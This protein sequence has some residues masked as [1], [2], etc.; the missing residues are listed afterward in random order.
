[1]RYLFS[2]K[3]YLFGKTN[4]AT[5]EVKM[6][7]IV[8]QYNKFPIPKE[9]MDKL[10]EIA[11]DYSKV[12]NHVYQRYGGIG[13][14]S[15][16]YPGYTVQ[17][18]MT[19]SG[20]RERLG[21]PSVYF[22]LAIFDALGDIKTQWSKTRNSILEAIRKNETFSD[23]DRHYIRAVLKSEKAWDSVLIGKALPN[24]RELPDSS[25]K[26]NQYLRRQ[27]RKY[28][29]KM[30]TDKVEGFSIGERAYRYADDGIY[31]ST[32]EKRQRVYVPLTDNNRYKRQLKIMLHPEDN[33]L[34]ILV[35]IDVRTK[36]HDD[37]INEIGIN[38]SIYTMLT[39]SNGNKYGDE[40]GKKLADKAKWIGSHRIK[41][42]EQQSLDT[43]KI[44]R[45]KYQS[46][47]NKIDE[48][49][50]I[51]INTE[52]NRFIKA[53][54]PAIIYMPKLPSNAFGGN[55]SSNNYMTTIWEHGYIRKRLAQKCEE[56][57]IKLVEVYAKNISNECSSCHN[58]GSQ[59]LGIKK[60]GKF[61]CSVCGSIID[62]KTNAA[63]NALNR[64]RS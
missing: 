34:E 21:L 15:K 7:K 2:K 19:D 37:Y 24:D 53:E 27:T 26:L 13:G 12:K 60:D 4:T 5:P 58:N 8:R 52:L 23:E 59:T 9:D 30:H 51:Y 43:N 40:L 49:L 39:V 48:S 38:M 1:M 16:I 3:V 62:E 35:P 61:I 18:E 44:G 14:F 57:N 31:I 6:L 42:K 28:L 56:N 33:S 25:N 36:T 50:H 47:K 29:A 10:L 55:Y 64:G 63:L 46:N 17:N 20:L 22:Y 41:Y 32:K 54:K 11:S 45:K